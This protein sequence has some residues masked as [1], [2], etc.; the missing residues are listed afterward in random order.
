MCILNLYENELRCNI[1]RDFLLNNF[2]PVVDRYHILI[3]CNTYIL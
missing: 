3:G 2:L 1:L